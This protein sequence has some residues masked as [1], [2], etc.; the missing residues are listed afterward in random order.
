MGRGILYNLYFSSKNSLHSS[1]EGGALD[2]SPLKSGGAPR[3]PNKSSRVWFLPFL[4][5]WKLVARA[6]YMKSIWIQTRWSKGW[7]DNCCGWP[8]DHRGFTVPLM[9][10]F[11][12]IPP[13]KF[14]ENKSKLFWKI[15]IWSTYA[16]FM[17]S[18]LVCVLSLTL[19]WL[20]VTFL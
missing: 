4:W 8:A 12:I 10:V 3:E 11:K 5:A 17:R 2:S 1:K 20:P 14:L 15:L 19:L 6:A 9:V 13:N 16:C 7:N 18:S